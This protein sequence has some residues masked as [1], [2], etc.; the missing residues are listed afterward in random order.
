MKL[1]V[2]C[3][4]HFHFTEE[5]ALIL[6][7]RP[8]RGIQQWINREAFTI[9]PAMLMLESTDS[10][11]NSYQ[12]VLAPIGDFFIHTSAEVIVTDNIDITPGAYFVEIQHLPNEILPYLLPS[13]Y[14]ESDRF[15]D[16]AREIIVDAL[17]GYDQVRKITDWVQDAIQ[18][19]PGSSEFPLSAVEVHHRGNG[20]CR[21]LAQLCI[22]LCR[23]ISI[24][25]RLVVG[26][27]YNLQPMD[28]HAWFEAYVGN[29]WYTF[30]P[31]Q[32]VL[33]G[34]RVIIAFGRDAADVS[35]F[36]QFGSGC[37]LN[38]MDVQ[39]DLLDN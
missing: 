3:N 21:D 12:R 19:I 11:G 1:V 18:Y 7:L 33:S 31:T 17:P 36:H 35:I 30:D 29:R 10:F 32:S 37:V 13:R 25:A 16:L 27:L 28:L 9:N 38:N 15:G 5:T 34:G 2:N 23:S 8:F 4:L 20:V 26:Y 24:P 39:V 6:M 14:C 22:A